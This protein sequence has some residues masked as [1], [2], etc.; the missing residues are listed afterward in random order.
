MVF[1]IILIDYQYLQES[2]TPKKKFEKK[3]IPEKTQ[4]PYKFSFEVLKNP[5][6]LNSLLN[7]EK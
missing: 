6:D 2:E 3:I 5:Q 7:N 4:K 1:Y